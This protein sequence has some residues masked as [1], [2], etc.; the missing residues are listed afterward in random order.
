MDHHGRHE[1]VHGRP[2]RGV[3]PWTERPPGKLSCAARPVVLAVGELSAASTDA[4]ESAFDVLESDI[5]PPAWKV[6]DWQ[7]V[8]VVVLGP[9]LQG[10][11]ASR[12]VAETRQRSPALA[13]RFVVLAAGDD[14]SLFQPFIDDD[15]VF[16]LS[17]R[18]LDADQL[19]AIVVSA[20][21]CWD[22]SGPARTSGFESADTLS[23]LR[24]LV[25]AAQ[26][27]TVQSDTPAIAEL[28]S[29]AVRA[30]VSADRAYCLVYDAR[31]HLLRSSTRTGEERIESAAAGI[32]SFAA[33]TGLPQCVP[34]V[35]DDSRYEREADDPVG[36]GDERLLVVPVV[37]DE[38]DGTLAVLVAVRAASRPE[39]SAED[40]RTLHLLSR[41][42][43]FALGRLALYA[44]LER[45]AVEG[46]T[47]L[48]NVSTD[49][50][51][52]EALRH[53]ASAGDHGD[54]LRISEGWMKW[55]YWLLALSALA[56]LLY[57]SLA[58]VH[59]FATGVAVVRLEDIAVGSDTGQ[60]IP[61]QGRA[62]DVVVLL[63]VR[64]M[65]ALRVGTPL[66]IELNGLPNEPQYF[67]VASVDDTVAPR[68]EAER[69]VGS[70]VSIDV[71]PPGPIVK[72]RAELH[73]RIVLV[74]GQRYPYYDGMVGTARVRVGSERLLTSLVPTL[75]AVVR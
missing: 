6:L 12:F 59:E 42:V 46:G 62:G 34:R 21:R 25:D 1:V 31:N 3:S 7:E 29:A 53:H 74:R 44:Q 64:Y 8:A 11:K 16:F 61:D 50:Y 4:L 60:A 52:E 67:T 49:V 30:V 57:V 20:S 47:S 36:A 43:G 72:V 10:A 45:A 69:Y 17:R 35:L 48:A 2:W 9:G 33:R 14:P 27:I 15:T 24:T 37:D 39:F 55:T 58:W 54:V 18:P 75:K 13:T 73:S 71:L 38:G 22:R 23:R 41:H 19:L 63:P 66:W 70:P 56:A 5:G 28:S 68:A 40:R 51:R 65:P 26:A 32:V